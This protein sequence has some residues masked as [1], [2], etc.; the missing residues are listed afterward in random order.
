MRGPNPSRARLGSSTT[1]IH[2]PAPTV[3]S[4]CESLPAHNRL[5][6]L[7]NTRPRHLTDLGRP[8]P[9]ETTSRNRPG[10]PGLT[11]DHVT[12]Q[13]WTLPDPFLTHALRSSSPP[14]ITERGGGYAQVGQ[15]ALSR[16]Q[17]Q[18]LGCPQPGLH[19]RGA[20]GAPHPPGS[21]EQAAGWLR[22]EAAVGTQPLHATPGGLGSRSE[23]QAAQ[24]PGD[25]TARAMCRVTV[26]PATVCTLPPCSSRNGLFCP[27]GC[28]GQGRTGGAGGAARHT[29]RGQGP[30]QGPHCP[31]QVGGA[32]GCQGPTWG[33]AVLPEHMG[34]HAVLG[35]EEPVAAGHRTPAL[36]GSH[37]LQVLLGVDVEAAPRRE[38]G[39]APWG[40]RTAA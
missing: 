18:L 24:R 2:S 17:Q 16:V 28:P 29:G 27:H 3:T 14:R 13:M 34:L 1:D 39:A 32:R 38:P 21:G 7:P 26:G 33:P 12:S 4:S 5:P 10:R 22:G 30:L 23:S 6:H 15:A 37:V 25:R 36:R 31:G 35:G 11:R 8:R 20:A 9:N 19:P 40:E